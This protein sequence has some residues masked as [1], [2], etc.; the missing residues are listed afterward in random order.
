ML[1]F[2]MKPE[3]NNIGYSA[4]LMKETLIPKEVDDPREMHLE[5]LL[6]SRGVILL[7]TLWSLV[8]YYK[9][10]GL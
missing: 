6:R 7:A 8:N 9:P 1:M 3:N 2:F 10:D 4:Y 5:I